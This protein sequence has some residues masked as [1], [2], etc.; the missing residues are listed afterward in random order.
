MDDI[1]R[2]KV[3]REELVGLLLG[4]VEQ[5]YELATMRLPTR[6]RTVARHYLKLEGLGRD[7][8][9]LSAALRILETRVKD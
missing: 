9:S 6:S 4:A 1:T 7:A 8:A 2:S 3:T 5:A